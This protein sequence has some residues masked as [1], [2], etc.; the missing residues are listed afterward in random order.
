MFELNRRSELADFGYIAC[1]NINLA[2]MKKKSCSVGLTI[3]RSFRNSSVVVLYESNTILKFVVEFISYDI[4]WK[5]KEW[6]T[7]LVPYEC[8]HVCIPV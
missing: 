1:K 3:N 2:K 4:I 8:S 7:Y 5:I 6:S